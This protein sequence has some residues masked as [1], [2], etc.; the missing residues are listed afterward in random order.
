VRY[1]QGFVEKPEG[2]RQLGQPKLRW[3]C[4][5]NLDLQEVEG[6]DWTDESQERER[7]LEL[8]EVVVNLRVQ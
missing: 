8:V 4:N 5:T 3:E 7:W 1:I 2:K 6:V